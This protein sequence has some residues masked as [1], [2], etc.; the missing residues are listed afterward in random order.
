MTAALSPSTQHAPVNRLDESPNGDFAALLEK[1]SHVSLY[2]KVTDPLSYVEK[3][4]E[5]IAK[6]GVAGCTKPAEGVCLAWALVEMRMNWIQF[7]SEY[8]MV[9]GKPTLQAHV[10]L[11]RIRKAGGDVE[12]LKDG[13]DMIEARAIFSI[14]G[15][16]SELAYTMATAK[17]AGVIKKDGGWEKNP[18]AMLRAALMRKAAKMLC[19][20]VLTGDVDPEE[21]SGIDEASQAPAKP[22]RTKEQTAARAAEL[23]KEAVV[24]AAESGKPAPVETTTTTAAP[25]AGAIATAKETAP[26]DTAK[27][28]TTATDPTAAQSAA[29]ELT[30]VLLE[31]EATIGEAGITKEKLEAGLRAKNPKFTSLDDM[32]L[33]GATGL[34]ANVRSKIVKK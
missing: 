32:S 34:L 18:A 24:A 3:M 27:A 13:E 2:D 33:E 20:E 7:A 8:H 22:T 31:I 15:R 10:I 21:F 25:L 17:L 23:Q 12:W 19:P 9:Q 28:T 4:G 30:A 6:A 16:K 1:Q 26:F 14:S 11:A 29:N 5:A